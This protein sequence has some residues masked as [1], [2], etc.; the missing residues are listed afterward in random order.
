MSEWWTYRLPDF[1]LFSARTYY[2]LFELYNAEAWP[3]HLAAFALGLALL[4]VSLRDSPGSARAACAMLAVCWLWVAW[5]FHL[6]RYA[7]INWAATW[8]AAAFAIEGLL[9]LLGAAFGARLGIR[10][11]RGWRAHVGLGLLFFALCIQPWLGVLQGRPWRQAEVFGLA[12]DPTALATLGLLLLLR[13]V[14][15]AGGPASRAPFALARVLWP[16]PL[17]WCLIGAA[18]LWAMRAQGQAAP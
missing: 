17:L 2:R 16:I 12:P 18:T 14:D 10:T 7:T 9:L 4:F 13:P 1:L 15:K 11:R 5:A 6:Q 8:F 3:A